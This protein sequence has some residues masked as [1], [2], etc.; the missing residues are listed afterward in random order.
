M[1]KITT[2]LVSV[3]CAMFFG[4]MSANA[5]KSIVIN[6]ADNTNIM[7]LIESTM[8]TSIAE[9]N[10]IVTSSKGDVIL[11]VA[12][13]KNWTFSTD[14]DSENLWTDLEKIDGDA[15]CVQLRD[16]IV[17]NNLPD[18]SQI[19]L[20]T[21]NGK[22]ICTASVNGSYELSLNDLPKGVYLLNYNRQTI[23]IVIAQ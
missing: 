3:V 10:L 11:P 17:L 21:A 22:Q 15:T 20:F 12:E 16:K 13:V 5:Y 6:K 8:T 2:T 1:K 14:E 9:G 19:A 23:K 7:V 4:T 18:G